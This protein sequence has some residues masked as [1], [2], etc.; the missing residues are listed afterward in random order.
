MT[1]YMVVDNDI[2]HGSYAYM[3]VVKFARKADSNDQGPM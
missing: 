2:H 1:F 3:I